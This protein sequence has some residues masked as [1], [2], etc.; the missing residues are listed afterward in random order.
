MQNQLMEGVWTN[1]VV[2]SCNRLRV[3]F[4]SLISSFLS[5]AFGMISGGEMKLH[6]QC[7]S[8]GTEKWDINSI[9]SSEVTWLGTPCL[10]KTWRMKSCASC[11]N[12]ML[13]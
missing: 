7:S 8:E 12:V 3:L 9:P 6:V 11:W 10:E 2:G 4:Q 13:S 5:V 1:C